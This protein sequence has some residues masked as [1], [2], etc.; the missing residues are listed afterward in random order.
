MFWEVIL[1]T[2]FLRFIAANKIDTKNCPQPEDSF[3]LSLNLI[4]SEEVTEHLHRSVTV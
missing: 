2:I 4:A 1:K 3:E